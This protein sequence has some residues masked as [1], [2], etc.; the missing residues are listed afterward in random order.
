MQKILVLLL[1]LTA[2]SSA[3]YSQQPASIS[4]YVI[5][6]SNR[7][8]LE[9]VNVYISNTSLGAS[10]DRDG[11]F[12]IKSIP[13]GIHELV[14]S[15]VGYEY[16][17]KSLLTKKESDLRLRFELRPVIY[18]TESTEILGEY[19]TDWLEDLA[20]FKRLF[21]GQSDF[22]SNC[23][24]ENQEVLDFFW[25][26]DTLRARAVQPLSVV[27]LSMG[28]Y[29][30]CILV[31][32]M[33]DNT[34]HRCSWLIKPEYNDL[35]GRDD[36]D[37]NLWSANRREA[38]GGSL[39]HFLNCIVN[40]TLRDDGYVLYFV[41]RAGE[42]DSKEELLQT[43]V[44]YDTLLNPGDI[45]GEY[46]LEFHGY[47]CIVYNDFQVS[48]IRLNSPGVILNSWGHPQEPKPFDVF[49]YWASRGIADFLP[50]F[51]DPERVQFE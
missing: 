14:V 23:Y 2:F 3:A 31:N 36:L 34:A 38:Y 15:I 20:T 44:P 16:Q 51:Y 4:G 8:P 37:Y 9:N 26:G 41:D 39:A 7:K 18:E 17:T 42:R 48:W 28:Y 19:P 13:P 43:I 21:L 25:I 35:E 24:I 29:I 6:G 27:N 47:L 33:W 40:R 22:A 50:S 10:T 11:Y 45:A 1:F 5:D 12:H 32:F 30:N 46:A 49:G